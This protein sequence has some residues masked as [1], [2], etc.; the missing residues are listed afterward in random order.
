MVDFAELLLRSYELLSNQ[1]HLRQHYQERFQHVLI[2]EFQDTNRLQY[3]WL[4][5]FAGP[6]TTLM[7]VGDDDQSIYAFRG[8]HT[9]N[10]QEFQRDFAG[11]RL[12]RLEQNYRSHGAILDAAN[13]LISRNPHRLGKQLWT[14]AGQGEPIRVFMAESD[15]EEAAW[16]CE[17]ARQQHA[18]GHRLSDM[19]ILYRSNAQSR[20]L[21]HT[22]FAAGIA[23]RVY[24][25]LRFFERQEIK[26]TLAYLRLLVNPDDDSSL[27]RV[28]N[29]PARGIGAKSLEQLTE[30]AQ[31]QQSSLW[32]VCLQQPVGKS[33]ER[34]VA[35]FVQLIQ[36][37]REETR[38]MSLPDC[39]AHVV[40]FSGIKPFYRNEPDNQDR[41]ENLDELVNAGHLFERES[42]AEHAPDNHLADFLALASLE[43]GNHQANAGEDALQLMT[44]HAAKGLEFDI[45][46]LTGL[47]EGLFPSEQSMTESRGI[48]EERRL[49]YVAI[50]RARK[51]LFMTYAGRR[52]LHGRERY[53]IASRF[54]A[55][56]PDHLRVDV[57]PRQ[58]RSFSQTTL[59]SNSTPVAAVALTAHK[60]SASPWRVGLTVYHAKFG[61]GVILAVA[62]MGNDLRVQ[63]KF[64]AAHGTK[65][66]AMAYAKLEAR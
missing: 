28:I 33:T 62:G 36:R 24:G 16:V 8:A 39:I 14:D 35:A 43:A 30:S 20:E 44:I 53:G 17:Q 59:A 12:I 1:D 19:A 49:M 52:M 31:A 50:T 6:H 32:R 5:L 25:G 65:W 3:R 18:E 54:L 23:Y 56:I 38:A 26:H 46:F 15:R 47:E 40:E 21:E 55:E 48:E 2:D 22:L 41:L 57:R 58:M 27:L 63:V 61:D 45:V 9:G 34:G 42:A 66:L 37:L 13:A 7:A 11:D 60:A 4:K 10:M 64:G 51:Q 29:F